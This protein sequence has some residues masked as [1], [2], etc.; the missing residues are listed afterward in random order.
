M[1]AVIR[2]Q[3]LLATLT[4]ALLTLL[5]TTAA[6]APPIAW[7]NG[8]SWTPFDQ[9][10]VRAK[11]ENKAVCVVVYADWCPKCRGLAPVFEGP[12]LTVASKEVIMV[13][14][15]SEE[16]PGWLSERFG[17]LGNYV[18]RVFFLRPDGSVNHDLGSG[19]PRYPFF[20]T[21][22][23]A[24]LLAKNIHTAAHAAGGPAVVAPPQPAAPANP[25]AAT[26]KGGF[27]DDYGLL[28][29]FGLL[30]LIGVVVSRLG[31]KEP[32]A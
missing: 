12:P 29:L 28:V 10:V 31:R 32:Q 22:G 25:V 26:S 23:K 30:V 3:L 13:L 2:K 7:N 6:A 11:A 4:G 17:D 15:N 16:R 1:E 24:E 27:G 5:A 21:P 8:I 18:P 14:Q 20:Y 9:A 19:H